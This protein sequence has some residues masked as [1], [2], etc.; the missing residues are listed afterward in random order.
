MRMSPLRLKDYD[1][2][3]VHSLKV[4]FLRRVT[5]TVTGGQ[6]LYK[7]IM[8]I[9]EGLGRS[10]LLPNI[11][12]WKLNDLMGMSRPG[13]EHSTFRMQDECS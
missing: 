2:S 10:H 12:Q 13:F 9:F 6:P 4:R 7:Y 8:V 3:S 1:S 11:S 5:T